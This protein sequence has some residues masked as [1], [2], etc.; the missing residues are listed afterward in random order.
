MSHD[1]TAAASH[2]NAHFIVCFNSVLQVCERYNATTVLSGPTDCSV[3]NQ[4]V[5]V[6]DI[7]NNPPRFSQNGNY[8][9]DLAESP[10]DGTPVISIQVTDADQVRL[11]YVLRNL[12]YICT[13]NM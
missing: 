13:F 12:K 9:E 2:S 10:T 11:H 6:L 3:F 7:N 5:T 1:T 4:Q 8:N